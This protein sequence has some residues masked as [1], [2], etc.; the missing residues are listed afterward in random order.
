MPKMYHDRAVEFNGLS[1]REQVL[2]GKRIGI[3][4]KGGSGKS[5][6]TVLLAK[7]LKKSGYDVCVLDADSTNIG[8]AQ[9]LGIEKPPA[10]LLDYFGGAVTYP[11]DDPMP[12]IGADLAIDDLPEAYYGRSPDGIQFFVAGKMGDKGPGARCDRPIAEIVRDFRPR[13]EG[14]QPVTLVDFRAGFEDST[15]RSIVNLDWIVVVI[16]PTMAAVQMAI[17]M[18]E[19]VNQIRVGGRVFFVLNRV[20]DALTE[21]FL[22]VRLAEEGIEPLG[23]IPETPALSMAW[24]M[25]EPVITTPA[26]AEAEWIVK[27]LETAVNHTTLSA[28]KRDKLLEGVAWADLDQNNHSSE[29]WQPRSGRNATVASKRPSPESYWY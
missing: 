15:R 27:Q 17:N 1:L 19:M 25:G 14:Q 22:R 16:D 11:M 28:D 9:A 6:V 3:F 2:N 18:Q 12:L 29:V 4:G 5:S 20:Q 10:P 7:A 23:V 13:Y 21:R 8:L 24:L 26:Q